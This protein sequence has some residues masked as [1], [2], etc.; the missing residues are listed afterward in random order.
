M[1][2]MPSK[3]YRVHAAECLAWAMKAVDA[4]TRSTMRRMAIAWT[5]LAEQAERNQQND[6]VYE[7]P[8]RSE[9]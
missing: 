4:D 9:S 7:T 1:P 2:A 3:I 5:D 6:M 8:D